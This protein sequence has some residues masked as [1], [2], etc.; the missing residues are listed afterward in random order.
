MGCEPRLQS[1][2][3]QEGICVKNARGG[4]ETFDEVLSPGQHIITAA[5]RIGSPR[6]SL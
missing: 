1:D 4:G 5:F 2:Q 3:A 6:V